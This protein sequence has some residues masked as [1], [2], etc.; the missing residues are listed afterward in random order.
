MEKNLS[1]SPALDERLGEKSIL[2]LVASVILINE[3]KE[4]LL[5]Q[6]I[7]KNLSIMKDLWEFPGGKIEDGETPEAALVRELKEELNIEVFPSCLCPMTFASY[8]YKE[9]HLLMP[10]FSCRK[11]NGEVIGNEGQE[12]RWVKVNELKN[13]KMPPA[14]YNILGLI[15]DLI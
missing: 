2:L 10:I 4:I 14:N 12:V 3:K 9:F 8:K 15:S 13:Y 5:A 11:F 1:C 7:G 6:R